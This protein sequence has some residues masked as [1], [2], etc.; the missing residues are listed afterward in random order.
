MNYFLSMSFWSN[1]FLMGANRWLG[2]DIRTHLNEY[3]FCYVISLKNMLLTSPKLT[4]SLMYSI[5]YLIIYTSW[6]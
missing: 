1:I 5:A 2:Y 6:S 3:L 4:C